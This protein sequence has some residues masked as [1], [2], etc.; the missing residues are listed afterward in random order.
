MNFEIT[1]SE[2]FFQETSGNDLSYDL[3]HAK[4]LA[5]AVRQKEILERLGTFK[6]YLDPILSFGTILA[7]VP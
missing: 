5:Y 3:D 1:A 7:E 2:I 6:H 4:A